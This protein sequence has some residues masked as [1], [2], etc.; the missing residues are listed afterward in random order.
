MTLKRQVF[1][2]H[3]KRITA[4]AA[5]ILLLV[6]A[7][8]GKKAPEP[9]ATR[10]VTAAV[11]ETEAAAEAPAG[12]VNPFTGIAGYSEA[13]LGVKAVGV[14]V[15]NSPSARP[16]W[17]M[18]TPD[19]VLEYEVEGGISRMLWIY[20]DPGVVP[21]AVGPVRSARHDIVELALGWDLIFIHCGGSPA[22]LALIKDYA[23]VLYEVEGLRYDGCFTRD[24]S[25]NVSSEHTLVLQGEKLQASLAQLGVDMAVDPAKAAPLAF[26]KENAPRALTGGEGASLHIEYSSAYTYDFR[27]DASTGRYDQS[28]N[29]APVSDAEG[30]SCAYTNVLVL[31]VD[32]VDLGDS[33]GHLD[34]L[35]E[36]GGEGLYL[37]GGRQEKI[38]W[39][40]GG[41]R[42]PLRL[43]TPDGAPL[44]LNPGNSYIGFVRSSRAGK[45]VLNDGAIG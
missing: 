38:R 43:L 20:A 18:S 27:Y 31:Y 23:G 42:D 10:P 32:T 29:G 36:N 28:L 7:G 17:G 8:C 5:A 41:D 12:P 3:I 16:Q 33:D 44:A 9:P 11:P 22:A 40:K 6:G 30:I 45:T 25:R 15:E 24:G 35:L 37:C 4:A 14:V 34:L 21:A 13:S 1:T 19:A 26:E 2:V 39:E